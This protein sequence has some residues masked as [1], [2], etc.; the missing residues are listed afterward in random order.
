MLALTGLLRG[1]FDEVVGDFRCQLRSAL[2]KLKVNELGDERIILRERFR[3]DAQ[4]AH[5]RHSILELAMRN[6]LVHLIHLRFDPPQDRR[7]EVCIAVKAGARLIAEGYIRFE[8][9]GWQNAGRCGP[10]WQSVEFS[11]KSS[12]SSPPSPFYLLNRKV[13][14]R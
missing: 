11:P 8:R 7:H 9:R 1:I 12:L 6:V 5:A 14:N 10:S 3:Q 2:T 4:L 13:K